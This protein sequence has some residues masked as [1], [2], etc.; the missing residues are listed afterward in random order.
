MI[1][2]YCPK[3]KQEVEFAKHENTSTCKTCFYIIKNK[4]MI[5]E[6][7]SNFM[8]WFYGRII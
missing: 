5:E 4:P 6:V 7:E 1:T 8:N 2:G 3:C